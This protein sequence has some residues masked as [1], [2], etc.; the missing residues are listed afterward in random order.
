MAPCSAAGAPPR[1][2]L[3][4]RGGLAPFLGWGG[5]R[6]VLP[7]GPLPK[8]REHKAVQG[9]ALPGR[10]QAAQHYPPPA[11]SPEKRR[12]KGHSAKD[13]RRR[14][15]RRRIRPELSACRRFVPRLAPSL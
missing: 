1:A 10:G 2:R 15:G 12:P 13:L 8:N 9:A 11:L 14:G 4:R 6:R 7:L 5:F 3:S